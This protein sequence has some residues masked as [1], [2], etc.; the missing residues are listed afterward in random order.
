C[1][2]VRGFAPRKTMEI[3]F[4]AP[5]NLVCNLDFVERIFG[6][7]GDPSLPENDSGLDPESWSG[8]TGCVILAP[9]LTTL[10]KKE[11]GLPPMAEASERQKRDGMCWE[12]EDE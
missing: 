10:R 4:F 8:H 3:R 12:K 2:E 1:P 6:N 5:G 11:L 9:H 7:G